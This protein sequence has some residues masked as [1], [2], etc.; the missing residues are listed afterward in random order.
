MKVIEKVCLFLL[1]VHRSLYAIGS[2]IIK[3]SGYRGF[4]MGL[5][6]AAVQVAPYTGFQFGFYSFF[7]H[8]LMKKDGTP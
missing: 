6:P 3:K 1:K 5:W 2:T 7:S 4:F 8:L